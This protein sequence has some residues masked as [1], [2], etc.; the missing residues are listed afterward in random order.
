[1]AEFNYIYIIYDST[2]YCSSFLT[3]EM[4]QNLHLFETFLK[5]SKFSIKS[6]PKWEQQMESDDIP[7]TLW[8]L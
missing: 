7:S 2:I 4:S 3:L 6:C 8:F 5:G 1:M